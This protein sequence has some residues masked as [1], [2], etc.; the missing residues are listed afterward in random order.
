MKQ[1]FSLLFLIISFV[2]SAQIV[3][4]VIQIDTITETI[5]V[6]YKLS[7]ST[8]YYTKKIAVFADDTSQI[9]IEKSYVKNVQSGLYKVFYPD[10]GLKIKT[11]FA[12]N[13][14][15]GEW[16]YYN[17][18]GVTNI[19]GNYENGIKHGY[20]AY[21]SLKIY[22]RYKKGL[23]FWK[24]HRINDNKK[25][26]KSTYKKGILVRGE[27]F[28]NDNVLIL[29]DSSQ[30]IKKEPQEENKDLIGKEYKQAISFL[31]ENLVFKKALK[32]HFSN[33]NLKEVRKLKKHFF[34]GQFQFVIA[35]LTMGLALDSFVEESKNG[36]IE[37]AI[38][39]SILKI[40]TEVQI[41]FSNSKVE[42]NR[43]LFN[44]STKISS[45]MV[46]YFS[47]IHENLLRIDVVR[48]D[49]TVA[50]DDFEKEYSASN[51]TQ[52]FQVLLYFNDEGK[53]SGAEYEKPQ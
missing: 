18:D 19:K 42:E 53:L 1:Y 35:P 23:K 24:W 52:R 14:I 21:K 33:G 9:A 17:P 12:S 31:S 46:V 38:I 44:N 28:G 39:D 11:V 26:V 47:N 48:F 16:V 3:E 15:N 30:I 32:E 29:S 50:K 13:K 4:E 36:K 41:L 40:N 27:G 34:R 2:S 25:R 45:T 22:G 8:T 10:G 6:I 5:K 43:M 37:V 49:A 51:R 7:V 20:W